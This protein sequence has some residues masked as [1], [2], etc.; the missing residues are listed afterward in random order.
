VPQGWRSEVIRFPLDFAPS[1]AHRGYE[2]LRFPPGMF[3][4]KDPEKRVWFLDQPIP[5]SVIDN[6][7]KQYYPQHPECVW[8][9]MVL[10]VLPIHPAQDTKGRH[11]GGVFK[12]YPDD[13]LRT[14]IEAQIDYYGEGMEFED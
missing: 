10:I 4:P 2:D 9:S 8:Q 7:C 3:D 5:L 14:E 12:P 11:A 13:T 1:L 6:F